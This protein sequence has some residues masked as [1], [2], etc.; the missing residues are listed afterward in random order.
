M[1][2][3]SRSPQIGE[4]IFKR[5]SRGFIIAVRFIHLPRG[6]D[7][8]LF[9]SART[10]HPRLGLSSAEI[11]EMPEKWMVQRQICRVG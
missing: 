5:A 4:A 11:G 3:L 10:G 9:D 1:V 8:L 2:F 6:F 7:G